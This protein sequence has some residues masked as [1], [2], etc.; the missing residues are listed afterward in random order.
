[1]E[2]TLLFAVLTGVGATWL[3][4]RV[5]SRRLEGIPH[6]VDT[7][8]GTATIG[9]FAGR[10]AAMVMA[11]VNPITNPFQILLVRAGVDTPVAATVAVGALLWATRVDLPRWIDALAPIGVAGLAGWHGGCVWRS[12]CLGAISDLPWAYALP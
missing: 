2:F 7:L 11:G 5:A 3:A 12:T 6:A 9:L 10:I 4:A 1:M 8:I